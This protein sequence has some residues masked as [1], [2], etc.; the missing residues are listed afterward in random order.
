MSV[1]A[2]C[3]T[4]LCWKLEGVSFA[5]IL[6]W[7]CH[8]NEAASSV[9]VT[10]ARVL[11]VGV[12]FFGRHVLSAGC[13]RMWGACTLSLLPISCGRC[14]NLQE[15]KARVQ[16]LQGQLAADVYIF[17]VWCDRRGV[18]AGD[19]GDTLG[20]LGCCSCVVRVGKCHGV[21]SW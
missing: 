13:R 17:G 8:E 20:C 18:P 5:D 9:A 1:A 16:G 6:Q 21:A 12:R 4:R 7:L 2:L 14:I 19:G 3:V 15:C 10:A 11:N